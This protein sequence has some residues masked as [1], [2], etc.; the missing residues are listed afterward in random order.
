[1]EKKPCACREKVITVKELPLCCPLPNERLRDGH[2]RVYLNIE[3][4]GHVT[5]PYCSTKYQL[6]A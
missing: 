2:P 4:T 5:C 3:K 6:S 1:M